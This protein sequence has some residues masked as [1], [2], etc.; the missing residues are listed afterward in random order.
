[1]CLLY[2]YWVNHYRMV[3]HVFCFVLFC[4]RAR[5]LY[6]RLKLFPVLVYISI[7]ISL[8]HL[9]IVHMLP[10]LVDPQDP[11]LYT[12][13]NILSSSA[14]V[15]TIYSFL[16]ENMWISLTLFFAFINWSTLVRFCLNA[17]PPC[18][19]Y[20]FQK[21]EKVPWLRKLTYYNVISKIKS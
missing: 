14:F 18:L 20:W 21:F 2:I 13:Y 17:C 6:L 19:A 3:V 1:M 12:Y 11:F 5:Y 4:F 16:L 10:N 8:S 7:N 9:K 15:Y